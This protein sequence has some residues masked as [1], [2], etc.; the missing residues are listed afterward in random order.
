MKYSVFIFVIFFAFGCRSR[1]DT[2]K[3]KAIRNIKLVE[4]L[5]DSQLDFEWFNAKIATSIET[6]EGTKR[7]FKTIVKMRRDSVI[8]M[9]I[10][11]LLG[12]EM[13]RVIITPDT[14]KFMDKVNNQYFI[15]GLDYL[16][17]SQNVDVD[18]D[19]MQQMIVSNALMFDVDEKFKSIKSED[20]YM[21][22]AKTKR[23]VRKSVG[24]KNRNTGTVMTRDTLA[25]EIDEKKYRKAL[26][27]NE[28][29]DLIIKRYWLSPEYQRPV[30]TLITDL[31]YDRTIAVDYKDFE[32]KD[33]LYF[34]QKVDYMFT[35]KDKTFAISLKYTR[36]KL[37][38][39]ESF[40]F[41]IP[42]DFERLYVNHEH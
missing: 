31:F 42:K 5:D 41:N 28:E 26:E 22:T 15:G 40:P 32:L 34:P 19:I 24:L 23:K 12:I 13:A 2:T 16:G 20:S 25:L 11:P 30:R 6:D 17:E 7:S 8:W 4:V 39:V 29:D 10:S 33:E 21:I 1:K 9:S 27:Q 36:T 3:L 14:L 35:E 37:N 38:N 18:F